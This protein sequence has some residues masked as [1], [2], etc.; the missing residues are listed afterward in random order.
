M[1]TQVLYHIISNS[2]RCLPP[3]LLTPSWSPGGEAPAAA[4]P[5][6]RSRVNVPDPRQTPPLTA[7]TLNHR[8]ITSYL[9]ATNHSDLNTRIC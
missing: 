8:F 6:R 3:E 9:Y 4:P 1:F 5:Q 2:A 7:P